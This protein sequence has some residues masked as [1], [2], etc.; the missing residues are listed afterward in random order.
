MLKNDYNL[1]GNNLVHNF[2]KII[3]QRGWNTYSYKLIC[4]KKSKNSELASVMEVL[5]QVL[6]N[7]RFQTIKNIN[8]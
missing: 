1:G 5:P 4:I 2:L 7:A 8:T 3:I 6:V